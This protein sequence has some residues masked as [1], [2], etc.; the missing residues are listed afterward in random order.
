MIRRLA[1]FAFAAAI[2]AACF[3]AGAYAA[4]RLGESLAAQGF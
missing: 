2:L 1:A 3:L 4:L